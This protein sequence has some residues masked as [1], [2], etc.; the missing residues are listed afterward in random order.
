MAE[1]TMV[2]EGTVSESERGMVVVTVDWNAGDAPDVV[3][4]VLVVVVTR[5]D[6]EPTVVG[7]NG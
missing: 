6:E 7:V 5:D 3:R 2:E 1:E 4:V